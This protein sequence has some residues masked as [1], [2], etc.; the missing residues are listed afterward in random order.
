V[1]IWFTLLPPV[2]RGISFGLDAANIAEEA[3]SYVWPCSARTDAVVR[4][5]AM[6]QRAS[7]TSAYGHRETLDCWERRAGNVDVIPE[8]VHKRRHPAGPLLPRRLSGR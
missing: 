3:Q 1:L 7:Y 5:I 4:P 6:T 2:Y 8:G